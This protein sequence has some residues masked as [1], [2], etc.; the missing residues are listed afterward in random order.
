MPNENLCRCLQES[1]SS[2]QAFGVIG[3]M[4]L[5]PSSAFIA[6]KNKPRGAD[7]TVESILVV[8]FFSSPPGVDDI[9]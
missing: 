9:L 3:W 7:I 5:S 8:Y 2:P 4:F 6:L 1:V